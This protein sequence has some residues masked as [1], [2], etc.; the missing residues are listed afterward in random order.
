MSLIEDN[1]VVQA[2]PT[3]GPDDAFDVGILPGRA[4]SSADGSQAEPFGGAAERRVEGRVTVVEEE[5]RGSVV[6]EGL[7]KL[8]AGSTRMWDTASR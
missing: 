7:A 8:L 6:W 1:H 2:L 3:D 4:W 5:S